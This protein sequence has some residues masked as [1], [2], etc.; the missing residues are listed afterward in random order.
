VIKRYKELKKHH[1]SLNVS[2]DNSM[3]EYNQCKGMLQSMFNQPLKGSE[4]VYLRW[5][6]L[7]YYVPVPLSIK[8]KML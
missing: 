6:R 5:D 3:T 2:S 4:K 1:S 8:D 7:N